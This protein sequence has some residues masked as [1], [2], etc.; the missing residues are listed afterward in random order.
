MSKTLIEIIDD[1]VDEH[2]KEGA[3]DR[4]LV[5]SWS[6]DTKEKAI[7]MLEKREVPTDLVENGEINGDE[8][9]Q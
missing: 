7:D 4:I 5:S 6:I 8:F 9:F 1:L 3:I 2:G